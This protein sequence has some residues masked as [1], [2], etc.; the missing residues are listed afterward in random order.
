MEAQY[1][2]KDVPGYVENKDEG[3][4]ITVSFRQTT[5]EQ[6]IKRESFGQSSYKR[7]WRPSDDDTE[8]TTYAETV[9]S[10]KPL[11]KILFVCLK[12]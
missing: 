8:G 6:T 7:E 2:I 4:W 11:E 10:Y 12:A 1:T 9:D 3:N 5:E